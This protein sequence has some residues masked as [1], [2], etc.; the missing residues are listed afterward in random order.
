MK[1]EHLIESSFFFLSPP[2][3]PCLF[4]RKQPIEFLSAYFS[5][6]AFCF[7]LKKALSVCSGNTVHHGMVSDHC[8]PYT[9]VVLVKFSKIKGLTLRKNHFLACN[10]WH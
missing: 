2:G 10:S 7:D 6:P 3:K 4:V 5:K 8:L 1:E 9:H